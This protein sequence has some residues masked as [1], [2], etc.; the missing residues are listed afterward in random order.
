MSRHVLNQHLNKVSSGSN[1]YR[2]SNI[3]TVH[4]E[5]SA[6]ENLPWVPRRKK[7]TVI[8]LV[9]VRV[10][11]TG[12]LCMSMPCESCIRRMQPIANKKNYRI[13][14]ILYSNEN[15]EIISIPYRNLESIMHKHKTRF[16]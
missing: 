11:K 3:P 16:M 6:L 9:V 5:I 13:R 7:H 2:V 8:D 14:N 10:S 15:G 12:L 1:Y 4:A